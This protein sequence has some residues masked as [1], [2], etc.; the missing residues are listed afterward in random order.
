M[1]TIHTDYVT[2]PLEN[3]NYAAITFDTEQEARD[4]WSSV[5]PIPQHFLKRQTL[6]DSSGNVVASRDV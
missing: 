5:I 1:W 6:V 4:W 3:G 2:V